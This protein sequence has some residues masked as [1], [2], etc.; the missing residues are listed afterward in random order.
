[1]SALILHHGEETTI[2]LGGFCMKIALI[3]DTHFGDPDGTLVVRSGAN[4]TPLP[5]P[6]YEAFKSAAGTDNDYLVLL[7]DV[8]DFAVTSYQEAYEIGKA[9][10]VQIQKDRIAN[11]LIYVPGNHDADIWYIVE[12]EVNII[13]RMLKGKMP[14]SFKMSVPGILDDRS[15][16]NRRGFTLA[17]VSKRTEPGEPNYAGLF[18]D[19]ITLDSTANPQGAPSFFN[20]AYPNLYLITDRES[21][22]MTHG[23]YLEAYWSLGSVWG[24]R[25]FQKKNLGITGDLD[26]KTMVGMN[27][28]LNQLASSGM[29]QAKPLTDVLFEIQTEMKRGKLTKTRRYFERL[30]DQLDEY[31]FDYAGWDPREWITDA[32]SKKLKNKILDVMSKVED[33]RYSTEFIKKPEVL[34]RFRDYYH[35]SCVEIRQVAEEEEPTYRS[36][37]M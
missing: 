29:G 17:G 32:L 15:Q 26:I 13:R 8:F 11:Q 6:K 27:F 36:P 28:P 14:Q 31:V 18:L 20:F 34:Q 12:H 25:I 30:D 4:N 7:G 22:L 3:S 24:L 19:S 35:A 23:H 33:T 5:G 2:M 9:F 1:M 16:S 21:V 37:H 10:F